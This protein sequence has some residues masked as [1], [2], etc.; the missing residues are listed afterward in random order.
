MFDVS[1]LTA[2]DV[3]APGFNATLDLSF[4]GFTNFNGF[5]DLS[6]HAMLTPWDATSLWGFNLANPPG[7]SWAAGDFSSA[8]YGPAVGTEQI[9][10]SG[11]TQTST[12]VTLTDPNALLANFY[13]TDAEALGLN[14]VTLDV[15]PI[16]QDWVNG[17]TPNLGLTLTSTAGQ[18]NFASSERSISNSL[19][20]DA[21][22]LVPGL[23]IP[24]GGSD[25]AVGERAPRLVITPGVIPEPSTYAL[26]FLGCVAIGLLMRR[27]NA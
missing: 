5:T 23:I 14:G 9:F 12:E 13:G 18:I 21:T 2:A 15:T 11:F 8:D 25:Y 24:A 19:L 6:A 22:A 3:N 26:V 7:F 16:V 4:Q 10:G 1:S 17:V 20:V 27:R